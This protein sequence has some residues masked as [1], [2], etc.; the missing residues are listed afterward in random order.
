MIFFGLRGENGLSGSDSESLL[1]NTKAFVLALS[2]A[3]LGLLTLTLDSVTGFM[4]HSLDCPSQ[5][6]DGRPFTAFLCTVKG[7]VHLIR[8]VNRPSSHQSS[9]YCYT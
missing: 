2:F 8:P 6:V 3:I 7:L 4:V 9:G 1:I 5:W